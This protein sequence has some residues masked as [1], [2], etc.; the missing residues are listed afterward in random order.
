M[1]LMRWFWVVAAGAWLLGGSGDPGLPPGPH[2]ADLDP[3]PPLPPLPE[4]VV[5][6]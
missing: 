5:R 6:G 1:T 4:M 3:S 2:Q